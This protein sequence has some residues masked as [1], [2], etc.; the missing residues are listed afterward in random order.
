MPSPGRLLLLLSAAPLWACAPKAAPGDDT[1]PPDSATD[2]PADSAETVPDADDTQ[3]QH[4]DAHTGDTGETGDTAP[5]TPLC[6]PGG[7]AVF[8]EEGE[9]L[10]AVAAC[11]GPGTASSIVATEVPPGATWDEATATLTWTPDLSQGGKWHL[12]LASAD[13][14]EDVGEI[15][16]WVADAWDRGDNVPVD[17]Y[18][19]QEEWG[20]PVVH[21][22]RPRDTSSSGEVPSEIVYRGRPYEI[23]LKYRGASSLYY[24]KNS[25]TLKFPPD[26]EFQDEVTGFPERRRIVLTSTFDD[27]SYV[28]QKLCYDIWNALDP[29]HQA[30][31]TRFAV[32]YINGAYEGLYLLGDHIDGEWWEDFGHDE[33]GNLYKAVDHSAN[34]YD[35]SNL[36]SGYEKKSGDNSWSDLTSFIRFVIDEPDESFAS[37]LAARA[38][39]E[40]FLDWWILVRF[41]EADDS[42]GKNSYLYSDPAEPRWYYAPW[43]FNH[44][45]GQQWETSRESVYTNYDFTAGNNLFRRILADPTLGPTL[46]DRYQ[47]ALEGP[48]AADVLDAQLDGYYAEIDP[49]A[50]RDWEKWGASYT[51]YFYWRSDYTTYDEEVS[52]LRGWVAERVAFME[53]LYPR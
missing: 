26:Q 1:A 25:Y 29:S 16:L 40:D 20:V 36:R 8:V 3:A 17:P 23:L 51:S 34:F 6:T 2:S 35:K 15:V 18:A 12:R 24:P 48:L 21:L 5:P 49:S 7:A 32:V 46:V 10:R 38:E 53:S 44:S 43:D 4:T 39:V 27:N 9:A 47:D 52:Y 13:D 31:E 22:T 45:F 19:Y 33:D 50:R 30:V 42:G 14:P 41:A 28:R 37:E 11:T